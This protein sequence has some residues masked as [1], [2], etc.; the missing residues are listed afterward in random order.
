MTFQYDGRLHDA[1][2]FRTILHASLSI[3]ISILNDNAC[4][5]FESLMLLSTLN[6]STGYHMHACIAD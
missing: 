1:I 2:N 5:V 3:M 4:C 6:T